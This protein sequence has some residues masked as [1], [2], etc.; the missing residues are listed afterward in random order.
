MGSSHVKQQLTLVHDSNDSFK[1]LA[2]VLLH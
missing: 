2:Y 1:E